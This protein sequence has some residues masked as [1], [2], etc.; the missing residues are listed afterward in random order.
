[1]RLNMVFQNVPQTR[2]LV[3]Q[4]DRPTAFITKSASTMLISKLCNAKNKTITKPLKALSKKSTKAWKNAEC[5]NDFLTIFIEI[6][7][8][9]GFHKFT[10]ILHKVFLLISRE[11]IS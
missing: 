7:T 6:C 4:T 11:K 9:K 3:K 10:R 5:N 1:M 8:F 2:H